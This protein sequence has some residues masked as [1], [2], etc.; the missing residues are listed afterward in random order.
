MVYLDTVVN[1]VVENGILYWDEIPEATGYRIKINGIIQS[2]VLSTNYYTGLTANASTEISI[3]PFSNN[4]QYFS[5]WSSPVAYRLL[6]SP[7]L[8]WNSALD[9]DGDANNNITWNGINGAIGYKVELIDPNGDTTEFTYGQSQRSFSDHY[10]LTG[11]YKVRVS[12]IADPLTSFSVSK[13]SQEITIN[14]LPAPVAATQ[15][16][17]SNPAVLQQ[18]FTATFN[19]VTGASKYELYKE[20]LLHLSTTQQQFSVFDVTSSNN[21]SKLNINYYIRAI[22]GVSSINDKIVVNLD[23]LTQSALSFEIIVLATPSQQTISG[24][25]YSWASVNDAYGYNVDISGNSI[26]SSQPQLNLSD[27]ESGRFQVRVNARG[28][29]SHVLPSNFTT[30]QIVNRLAKPTNIRIATLGVSEGQLL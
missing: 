2:Q 9:L 4:A 3:Q 10:S 22:G 12:A 13:F 5:S 8:S 30:T 21:T 29:G 28:N 6:P 24:Y 1:Q 25:E 19:A 23:S 18:G 20:G 17:T 7:T 11:T 15:F 26:I 16:I 27:L 14:R